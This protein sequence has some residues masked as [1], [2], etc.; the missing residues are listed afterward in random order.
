MLPLII[1]AA[2]MAAACPPADIT[3]SP[4]LYEVT[5]GARLSFYRTSDCADASCAER[6]YVVPGDRVVVYQHSGRR[7]C[8]IFEAARETTGWVDS[9][10]L[11]ADVAASHLPASAWTGTWYDGDDQIRLR[12]QAGDRLR[13]DGNAYWPGAHPTKDWPSGW[14]HIGQLGGTGT[15]IGNRVDYGEGD[16]GYACRATMRLL[17]E[18]LLVTDNGNCGGANVRFTGIYQRKH[19][20]S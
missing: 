4:R 7:S 1:L 20:R 18:Y 19:G 6:A 13:V 2:A 12:Q 11:W 3:E 17:G 10:R 16:E 14:P 9:D 8:A 5:A 15:V